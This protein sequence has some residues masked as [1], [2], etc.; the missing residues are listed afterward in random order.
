MLSCVSRPADSAAGYMEKF[1]ARDD[2]EGTEES[3]LALHIEEL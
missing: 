1:D 3:V 2:A